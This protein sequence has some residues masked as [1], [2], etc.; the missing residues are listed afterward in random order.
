MLHDLEENLSNYFE[1]HES[2]LLPLSYH[3]VRSRIGRVYTDANSRG[4]FPEQI[5]FWVY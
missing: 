1:A 2:F 5:D 3:L 4:N